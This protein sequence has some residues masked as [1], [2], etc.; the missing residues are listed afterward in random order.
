MVAERE[1]L[2]ALRSGKPTP[3][4]MGDLQEAIKQ[5]TPT[6]QEWFATAKNYA[7][8]ANAGGAYDDVLEHLKRLRM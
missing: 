7:I 6:V 3:V 8:Y 4:T 2:P 1:G 5:A